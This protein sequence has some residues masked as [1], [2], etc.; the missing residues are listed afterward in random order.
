MAIAKKQ[1][2]WAVDLDESGLIRSLNWF[3]SNRTTRFAK[4]EFVNYI[5]SNKLCD[6]KYLKQDFDFIPTDGFVSSLLSQGFS[7][8]H[9]SLIYF[10]RNIQETINSLIEKYNSKDKTR[11]KIVDNG[12]KVD[13][14]LGLVEHEVD[15]FLEDFSSEFKMFSFLSG[16]GIGV[17]ISRNYGKHY[18]KYLDELLESFDKKCKQLE[19]GYSFAGKRELNKY[20]K[21]LE[22]IIQDCETYASTR[23]KPRQK[24]GKKVSKKKTRQKLG[25]KKLE[26]ATTQ[27]NL[28]SNLKK[29]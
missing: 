11:A 19:E 16:N 4:K 9:S 29:I 22:E 8:P 25:K 28:D 10:N 1:P 3:N 27:A 7:I 17:N 18:Q 12:P 24:L 23:R 15:D 13:L 6:D 5:K 14:T 26:V 21:F 2:D 20:V